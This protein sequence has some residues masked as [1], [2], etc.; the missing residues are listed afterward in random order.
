[1]N[2][3]MELIENAKKMAG[4]ELAANEVE[5][6]A[7]VP[8]ENM[9]VVQLD[10]LVKDNDLEVPDTWYK[11]NKAD[12]QKY[13]LDKYGAP[14]E[15]TDEAVKAAATDDEA[16]P[17]QAVG[18]AEEST[19]QPEDG[20]AT[21]EA[22][23]ALAKA[24]S[25]KKGK[26]PEVLSK[27]ILSDAVH[28][29]ENLKEAKA[30]ELV[31]SMREDIDF[32]QFK[33]GGVLS[34]ISAHKWFNPYP[35]F[36]EYVE[37]EFG[38]YRRFAY[39]VEIYNK[40]VDSGIPYDKIK[41]V[42]WTKLKEIV[43]VL[44]TDNVDHWVQIAADPKITTIQ[45]QEIVKKAKQSNSLP[46]D[47]DQQKAKETTTLTFKVHEDQKATIKLAID[48]AKEVSGTT[49]DTVALDNICS[50]YLAGNAKPLW[51][52]LKE[53][54]IDKALEVFDKAFPDVQL[55]LTEKADKAA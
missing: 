12:K 38:H 30:K 17:M 27:D 14:E 5:E 32:A 21:K 52:R 10:A 49:T 42:G 15:G 47:E 25:K 26:D 39:F 41:L 19:V 48:K 1:M 50:D 36:K 13:L 29:I 24:A 37:A 46:S 11:M 6:Q 54:E 33:L 40:I 28:E 9:T 23:K 43:G 51:Q 55:M 3:S 35:T 22:A 18:T 20:T 45:L 2:A 34:V 16:Q 8:I 53:L 31:V 4:A 7:V 44:T